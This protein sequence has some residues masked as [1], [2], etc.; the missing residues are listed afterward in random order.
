MNQAGG[1]VGQTRNP[2]MVLLISAICGLYAIISMINMIN[3]LKN[4]LGKDVSWIQLFI[5]I[6][7]IIFLFSTLPKLVAEAKQKAG[8]PKPAMG[9]IVYLLVGP[10]ALAADLNDVW[11]GR[12]SLPQGT[13]A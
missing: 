2:V 8:S 7:N 10:Y 6:L 4:Y 3:E 5:P 12:G 1:A 11:A 13:P 9:G